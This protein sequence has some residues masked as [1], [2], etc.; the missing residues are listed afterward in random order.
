MGI[1]DWNAGIIRPV[2]VAPTGPYENGSAKG[3]W[4]L[5]Q[6]A[7]WSKQGLW[8]IA[9]NAVPVGLFAGGTGALP[10][11]NVIDKVTI[12]TLGNA[13]DFGDLSI[14]RAYLCAFSSSTRAVF[15]GGKLQSGAFTVYNVIE[16]CTFSTSGNTSDFG[17]LLNN[18]D[19]PVGFSN[20]TR[21]IAAGGYQNTTSSNVIQYVTIATTGNALDFGDLLTVSSGQATGLASSTRGVYAGGIVSGSF[22]NII[23]YVTIATTGN[24]TDFGD[25]LTG[26]GRLAGFSSSTRGVF[27][28]GTTGSGDINVLQYITIATTG[29]T[30]DF[31]DLTTVWSR[32]SGTSSPTRGLVGGGYKNSSTTN[33]IEYVTIATTGNSI[34][35]GD[36]TVARQDL[37]AC[38]NAHGGL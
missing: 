23:E 4:T 3:V 34:D 27:A 2:P 20:Q 22:A 30:V 8:P 24:A 9:G 7:Y 5:D 17:D 18:Y 33:V 25:L 15:A 38:S 13:T 16:Y 12:T 11:Y 19:A 29:N 36:L 6:V 31:G 26:T 1:K 35:F 37:S 32:A 28:G 10:E 21:G 14:A